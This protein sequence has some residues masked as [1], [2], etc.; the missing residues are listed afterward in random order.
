MPAW[1]TNRKNRSLW[2]N[3]KDSPG[4]PAQTEGVFSSLPFCK[5]RCFLSNYP[6]IID[7]QC[8]FLYTKRI[9]TGTNFLLCQQM[10]MKDIDEGE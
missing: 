9:K 7:E 10:V 5:S 3:F 2:D 8:Y 1:R 6:A 4:L